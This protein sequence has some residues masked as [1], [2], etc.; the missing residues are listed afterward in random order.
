VLV[1]DR[2]QCVVAPRRAAGLTDVNAQAS[3]RRNLDRMRPAVLGR[4][5]QGV[6]LEPVHRP[7]ID[8]G[9]RDE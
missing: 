3:V 2:L 8:G 9:L 7:F 5:M 6:G 1:E 4:R